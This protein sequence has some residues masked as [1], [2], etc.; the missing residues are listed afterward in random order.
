MKPSVT[1][2]FPSGAIEVSAVIKGYLVTRKYYGYS[3]RDAVAMFK[4]ENR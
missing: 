4:A 3:R 2:L 1:T